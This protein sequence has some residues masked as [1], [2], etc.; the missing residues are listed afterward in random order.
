M[1]TRI[2]EE[3]ETKARGLQRRIALC[4]TSDARILAAARTAFDRE[5]ARIAL[6]GE[7]DVIERVARDAN[8]NLRGIEIIEPKQYKQFD[9]LAN[10]YY[11]SRLGKLASLEAAAAELLASDLLF[12]AALASTGEVDGV[13]GGSVSTTGEVIRAALKGIGLA[14]GLSIL[15]SLFLLDFPAIAGSRADE[16][17]LVFADC[18]VVPDPTAEQLADIAIATAASYRALT[19]SEPRIAMLSFSTNGSATSVTTEKVR[20]ATALAKAKA[21]KLI[22][23][24]EMQFDA[25][26]MPDVARRKMPESPVA[27]RANV[28]IF[29]NLDAGNI[30]YK[31]AERLG[32]AQAIGPILQGLRKPMNDL[33]RGASVGDIVQMIAVTAIQNHDDAD[34]TD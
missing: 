3:I 25:A 14:E 8:V 22:L 18:A 31:I 27:G 4:D 28:F 34:S 10:W 2:L 1:A 6:I 5:I 32:M 9:T 16:F 29:P 7:R 13:L 21:P 24:G 33:S 15:S 30:G 20:A 17:V 26:F 19:G 11:L 12:A 23:D